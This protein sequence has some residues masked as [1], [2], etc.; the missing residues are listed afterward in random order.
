ME[1]PVPA[2]V[3]LTRLSQ[4]NRLLQL[5]EFVIGHAIRSYRETGGR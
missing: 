3:M 4:Q 1:M 2:R 5:E